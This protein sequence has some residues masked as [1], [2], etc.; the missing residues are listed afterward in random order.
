MSWNNH[1]TSS[2]GFSSTSVG[3]GGG[4]ASRTKISSSSQF[5]GSLRAAPGGGF[6][7]RSLLN[8]GFSKRVSSIS[9][10]QSGFGGG[11]GVGFGGG[12][13]G[14]SAFGLGGGFG[15][16]GGYG[17]GSG[18]A[19]A[20]I[21]NVTVNKQLLTPISV[22]IDP[23][24]SVVKKEEREQIKALNNKFASFIDKVLCYASDFCN[25]KCKV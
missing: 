11:S 19:N 15:A 1:F 18:P 9:S 20:G 5:G 23:N 8:A 4:G 14:T 17:V 22:D 6:G 2:R 10:S 21:V 24:I 16:G 12:F 7:S 13:G 25:L 3:G